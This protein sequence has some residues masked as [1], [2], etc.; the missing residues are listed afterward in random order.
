MWS[1]SN[2]LRVGLSSTAFSALEPM[3]RPTTLL[4]FF[5]SMDVSP[6]KV[7]CA[8][9]FLPGDWKL[10]AST[11]HR[12][13]KQGAVFYV[14]TKSCETFIWRGG[15]PKGSNNPGVGFLSLYN[16]SKIR[17]CFCN[18][19]ISNT[20]PYLSQHYFLTRFLGA[21]NHPFRLQTTTRPGRS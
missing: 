18:G 14:G 16:F 5:P 6:G 1:N 7:I 17:W 10:R 3:S 8:S 21:R 15:V 20:G 2:P 19:A 12:K 13:S 4:L 9:R 11:R